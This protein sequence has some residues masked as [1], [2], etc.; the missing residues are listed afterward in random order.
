MFTHGNDIGGGCPIDDNH[1]VKG[2]P[3]RLIQ[4]QAR[5]A[6]TMVQKQY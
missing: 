5:F 4:S 2:V 6:D 3:D 1:H